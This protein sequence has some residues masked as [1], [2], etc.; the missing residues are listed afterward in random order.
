MALGWLGRG[1]GPGVRLVNLTSHG[2]TV[3]RRG[4][5]GLRWPALRVPPS[6]A[7]ARVERDRAAA[8]VLRVV[9]GA[10]VERVWMDSQP[11]VVGVPECSPGV[12]LVVSRMVAEELGSRADVVFPLGAVRGVFGR[13]V[14]CWSFG[15]IGPAP[16]HEWSSD[17]RERV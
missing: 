7:V 16:E 13:V 1:T 14:G 15:S 8:S 10:F 4:W 3:W 5:W 2:V 12:V 9:G 11:N 17:G 6:G